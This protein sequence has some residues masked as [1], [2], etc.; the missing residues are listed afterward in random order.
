MKKTIIISLLTS[1]IFLSGCL[2]GKT[3]LDQAL[4]EVEKEKLNKAELE[5]L[6]QEEVEEYVKGLHE[7]YEE[8]PKSVEE[9][10]S[11][12]EEL[13]E[14]NV[15]DNMKVKVLSEYDDPTEFALYVSDILFKFYN[16]T[17]SPTDYLS[18]LNEHASHEFKRDFLTGDAEDDLLNIQA[19]QATFE[20]HQVLHTSYKVSEVKLKGGQR[21][22]Y[23]YRAVVL[24]VP[25]EQHYM[26][27]I[28]K[29]NNMW[30]FH[31]D[32]ASVPFV[33]LDYIESKKE[34]TIIEEEDE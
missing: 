34:E 21:E 10:L 33:E 6:E 8:N 17:I 5:A 31:E 18:F 1:T 11:E 24:D 12:L 2:F 20:D 26:V 14:L 13:E 9:A 30:K 4:N 28:K 29:E 19:V 15:L 25:I 22:G 32:K 23:F 16:R 7:F 3:P 27:T